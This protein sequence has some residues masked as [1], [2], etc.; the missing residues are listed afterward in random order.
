MS[1]SKEYPYVTRLDVQ[2]APMEVIDVVLMVE[3]EGIVPTGD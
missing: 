3:G 1:D 2:F